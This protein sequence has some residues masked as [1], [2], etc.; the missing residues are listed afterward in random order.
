MRGLADPAT[1][2]PAADLSSIIKADTHA[3]R[4]RDMARARLERARGEKLETEQQ[5][6]RLDFDLRQLRARQ[7]AMEQELA[8][9]RPGDT[10]PRFPGA[11]PATDAARSLIEQER[12]V[13]RQRARALDALR[14]GSRELQVQL[15][16]AEAV[17]SGLRDTLALIRGRVQATRA[18]LE[19]LQDSEDAQRIELDRAHATA[20]ELNAALADTAQ[21]AN[22]AG[23][24]LK[25]DTEALA[26]LEA[27][28]AAA[29]CRH[30]DATIEHTA[31]EQEALRAE[32][33][34]M[35]AK[36]RITEARDALA[37]A[38]RGLEQLEARRLEATR[39][40]AERQAATMAQEQD[41]AA[42]SALRL[43][44]TEM[45]AQCATGRS[46]QGAIERAISEQ[47]IA[48]ARDTETLAALETERQATLIR[49]G[50]T[51]RA[52]AADIDLAGTI[53]A[54][55]AAR[56]A[57]QVDLDTVRA[58]AAALADT[59][60]RETA[61]KARSA[62]LAEELRGALL[63]QQVDADHLR[64]AID[65]AAESG[66]TLRH[67]LAARYAVIETLQEQGRGLRLAQAR[68]EA[69]NAQF[70]A[71]ARTA[72]APHQIVSGD[73]APWIQVPQTPDEPPRR[74]SRTLAVTA[75]FACAAAAIYLIP[76]HWPPRTSTPAA[77]TRPPSAPPT[78]P[79]APIYPPDNG[80]FPALEL[81]RELG[82]RT[83]QP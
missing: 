78:A 81:S 15:A 27:K 79:P 44:M 34:L 76:G 59:L 41:R 69:S 22:A 58:E 74:R 35:A 67:D 52:I 37:L 7:A 23:A 17:E 16:D 32:A 73:V 12:T 55:T 46:A 53:A 9:A 14:Q 24:A 1:A 62:N 5:L 2:I 72:G 70:E 29:H 45:E 38:D 83:R 28:A 80:A 39:L 20:A 31:A 33:D 43:A 49:I 42:L 54:E 25:R 56:D 11:A 71:A 66:A 6:H 40:A 75:A 63:A 82:E 21:R 65:A 8:N 3:R 57:L 77:S 68:I 30:G 18:E 50:D 64:K 51:R 48:I 60:N 10:P 19:R 13:L 61:A 47:R 36:Q 4:L 26:A